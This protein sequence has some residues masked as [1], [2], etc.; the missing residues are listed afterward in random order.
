MIMSTKNVEK[1]T[2]KH[3]HRTCKQAAEASISRQVR[4]ETSQV[5]HS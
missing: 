5:K 1:D 3:P 4:S 2:I